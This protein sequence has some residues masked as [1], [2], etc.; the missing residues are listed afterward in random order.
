MFSAVVTGHAQALELEHSVLFE[1]SPQSWIH[2]E[3][4]VLRQSIMHRQHHESDIHVK[5][6]ERHVFLKPSVHSAIQS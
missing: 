1:F 5:R 3:I 4:S 6:V 2:R